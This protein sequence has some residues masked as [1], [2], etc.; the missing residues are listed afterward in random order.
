LKSSLFI[1]NFLGFSFL[2]F[3]FLDLSFPFKSQ[4]GSLF[5]LFL[6][7]C[8]VNENL[9]LH[10]SLFILPFKFILKDKLLLASDFSLVLELLGSLDLDLDLAV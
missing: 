4:F 10:F 3:N 2:S 5:L 1:G 7:S 8:L 6:E 9:P